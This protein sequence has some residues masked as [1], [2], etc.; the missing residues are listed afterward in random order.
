MSTCVMTS[1]LGPNNNLQRTHFIVEMGLKSLFR[2]HI[3][4]RATFSLA[5][6]QSDDYKKNAIISVTY[7][8]MIS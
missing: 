4:L 7:S 6:L 3:L 5:T 1:S 8:L 2:R